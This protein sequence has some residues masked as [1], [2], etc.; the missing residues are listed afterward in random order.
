VGDAEIAAAEKSGD[1]LAGG[2]RK[3][4]GLALFDNCARIAVVTAFA[5]ELDIVVFAA[6]PRGQQVFRL[7]PQDLRSGG[8]ARSASGR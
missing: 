6:K 8:E 7:K 2:T 3:E 4:G 1:S 5:P